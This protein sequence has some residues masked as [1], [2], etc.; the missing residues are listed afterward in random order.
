[1]EKR[2]V[3]ISPFN[4][5]SPANSKGIGNRIKEDMLIHISG[6]LGY[7]R[8]EGETNEQW[9]RARVEGPNYR[10]DLGKRGKRCSPS[11]V[12]VSLEESSSSFRTRLLISRN[13]KLRRYKMGKEEKKDDGDLLKE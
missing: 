6:T 5:V 10:R 11:K 2:F 8:I 3:K 7:T 9:A 13:S 4:E 12:K 1:M